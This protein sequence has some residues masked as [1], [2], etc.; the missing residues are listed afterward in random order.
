M[1]LLESLAAK[2]QTDGV[3][4][5][6]TNI[7]VS[8]KAT[9]PSGAGPYMTLIETGGIAPIRTQSDGSF[10]AYQRP[11]IQVMARATSYAAAKTMVENA[12]ASLV[13]L[14]GATVGLDVIIQMTPIQEPFDLG[15]DEA[16]R[17]RVV[18]NFAVL[19]R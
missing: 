4:T 11:Q 12:Y 8:S 6:G 14:Q 15:V 9:I 7:F 18:V 16:N 19:K 2:L 10:P 13:A 17:A 5:Y 1:G 3:G